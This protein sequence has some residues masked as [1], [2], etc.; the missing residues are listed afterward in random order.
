MR[1]FNVAQTSRSSQVLPARQGVFAVAGLLLAGSSLLSCGG[2][3]EVRNGV[4]DAL[5]RAT[6]RAATESLGNAPEDLFQETLATSLLG[7]FFDDIRATN[8]QP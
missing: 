7:L 5:E 4:I 2:C 8:V 3:P 6:V 1:R